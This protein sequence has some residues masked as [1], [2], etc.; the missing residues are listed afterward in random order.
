MFNI[1]LK[2]W[3]LCNSKKKSYL[4]QF[5]DTL[6]FRFPLYYFCQLRYTKNRTFVVQAKN[7]PF[8]WNKNNSF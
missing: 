5:F 6:Q 4:I 7:N 2:T 8:V 3:T 1:H